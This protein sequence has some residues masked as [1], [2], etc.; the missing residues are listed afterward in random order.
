LISDITW[1]TE[2]VHAGSGV[3]ISLRD[4][5]L[6]RKSFTDRLVA[7]AAESK[8][9][10]QLEVEGSGGSDG[11]ELQRSPWPFDW[12]FIGAPEL[13]AHTPHEQVHKNDI[14]AMLRLYQWLMP[15][16]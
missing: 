8:V 1:V 11:T 12:C 6:P 2:G 9:P 10:F 13:N 16:L 7:L 14:D 3:A 4:S 15:R 5:S